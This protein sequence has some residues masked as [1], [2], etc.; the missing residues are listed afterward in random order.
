MNP[1]FSLIFLPMIWIFMESDEPEIK[2]KQASKRDRNLEDCS[3]KGNFTPLCSVVEKRSP[4]QWPEG[5]INAT[6]RNAQR[7][8]GNVGTASTY[9]G[10]GNFWK[11]LI[12]FIHLC[13]HE[14]FLNY[15]PLLKMNISLI[16]YDYFFNYFMNVKLPLKLYFNPLSMQHTYMRGLG[17]YFW[18]KLA[19]D[20]IKNGVKS[21]MRFRLSMFCH[22]VG[23]F[24]ECDTN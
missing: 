1:R 17:C 6:T 21:Q 19:K 18:T 8:K 9:S 14:I 23:T 11:S 13:F 3:S 4:Q 20:W 10:Q 22:F 12:I 2:S 7:K 24:F 15:F 16:S 5:V